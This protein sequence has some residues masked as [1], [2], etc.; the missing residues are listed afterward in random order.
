M[1]LQLSSNKS[2]HE[3]IGKKVKICPESFFFLSFSVLISRK[4]NIQEAKAL[5]CSQIYLQV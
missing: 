1:R 3:E 5:L 4:G 2:D